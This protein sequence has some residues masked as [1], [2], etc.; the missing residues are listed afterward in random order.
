MKKNPVDYD[1]YT[2]DYEYFKEFV[3]EGDPLVVIDS[4]VF[5]DYYRYSSETSNEIL[6]ALNSV[7]EQIWIPYQVYSEFLRNHQKVKTE[8]HNKYKNISGD[9]DNY[10]KNFNKK[11]TKLF[12][13]YSKYDFPNIHE[14]KEKIKPLFSKINDEVKSYHKKIEDEVNANKELMTNNAIYDF[15]DSLKKSNQIGEALSGSK[16][17]H[18]VEEG[19]KRYQYNLPPG[20]EDKD[21]K[22]EKNE[23]PDPIRPYGDLIIWKSLLQKAKGDNLQILFTTSDSKEDWWQLDDQKNILGPRIELISEFNEIVGDNSE[24]LMLPMREF[25][26]YFSRLNKKSSIYAMIE[27]NTEEISKDYIREESLSFIETEL[28]H[29]GDLQ[30]FVDYG[31]LQDVEDLEIREININDYNTDFDDEMANITGSFSIQA[32]ANVTESM[33]KNYS[34]IDSYELEIEG[35]YSIEL[36]L[37]IEDESYSISDLEVSS[38]KFNHAEKENDSDYDFDNDLESLCV[39]CQKKF[40]D[41]TLYPDKPICSQC[42]NSGHYFVCTHCGTVYDE[43]DYNGDGEHCQLCIGNS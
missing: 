38:I 17:L 7:K 31:L 24:F 9:I 2:V 39:V 25:I 11:I 10:S 18:I 30:N 40:G 12:Q 23:K 29:N 36:E 22:P 16:L 15:I 4:S 28:I 13:Q 27:L 19:E 1:D 26:S 33:S 8:N 20:Y 5:L 3:E 21:K 35:T 37:D 42:A 41:V 6:E 34:R 43:G 14:L 32:T